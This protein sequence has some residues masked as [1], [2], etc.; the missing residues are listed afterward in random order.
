MK[1]LFSVFLAVAFALSMVGVAVAADNAPKAAKVKSR[2]ATGTIMAIDAAKGT[3]TVMG[4]IQALNAEAT[5][6]KGWKGNVDL[7]AGEQVTL[8]DFKVGDT[9][10][11]EYTDGKATSVK[12]LK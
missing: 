12:A 3:F 2:L 8:G 4:T 5:P 9:V 10:T 11:V 1:K 7:K 6:V